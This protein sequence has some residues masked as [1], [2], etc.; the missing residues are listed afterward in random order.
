M[1]LMTCFLRN[2]LREKSVLVTSAVIRY[3][4]FSDWTD[5]NVLKNDPLIRR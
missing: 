1:W 4:I 3:H 2:R 5:Y